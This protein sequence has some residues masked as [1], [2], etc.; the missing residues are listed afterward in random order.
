MSVVH[1]TSTPASD[2]LRGDDE[3]PLEDRAQVE[4]RPR[5]P[6]DLRVGKRR[7]DRSPPARERRPPEPRRSNRLLLSPLARLGHRLDRDH[8]SCSSV[9]SSRARFT[10]FTTTIVR[11]PARCLRRMSEASPSTSP[12]VTSARR[13]SFFARRRCRTTGCRASSSPSASSG[14]Q[15]TSCRT[16]TVRS[17]LG[18]SVALAQMVA[19]GAWVPNLY[20]GMRRVVPWLAAQRR[21]AAAHPRPIGNPR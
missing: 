8:G 4:P 16:S 20:V 11:V 3:R 12:T 1:E 10:V 18:S 15:S 5:A 2:Y 6:C 7:A 14:A 13:T 9:Y 19:D 21:R 17:Q